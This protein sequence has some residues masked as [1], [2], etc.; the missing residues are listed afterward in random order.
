MNTVVLQIP[1]K[2]LDTIIEGSPMRVRMSAKELGD[3]SGGVTFQIQL[4]DNK[5]PKRTQ[6]PGKRKP[7]KPTV[8]GEVL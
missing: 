7:V 8:E 5:A 4:G 6:I 2:A 3:T 1:R